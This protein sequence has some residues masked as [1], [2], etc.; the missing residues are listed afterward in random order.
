M[1]PYIN[2]TPDD[3]GLFDSERARF[4]PS[5]FTNVVKRK[6]IDH[7]TLTHVSRDPCPKCGVRGDI[8]CKHRRAA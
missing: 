6:G 5:P 1:R 8:G 3:R 7:D 2:D 4:A